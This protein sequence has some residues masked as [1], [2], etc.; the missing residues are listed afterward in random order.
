MSVIYKA[1]KNSI[2]TLELLSDSI[3]N[4]DRDG[5]VDSNSAKFRTNKARV[6]TIVNPL[7]GEKM[8]KDRSIHDSTFIYTVGNIVRGRFDSNINEVCSSGIHYFKTYDAALDWYCKYCES[9]YWK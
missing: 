2:V 7:T 9:L 3:T 8:D 6:V 1:C 5:V 4:E